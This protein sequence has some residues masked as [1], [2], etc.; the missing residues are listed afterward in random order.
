MSNSADVETLVKE[1]R[2]AEAATKVLA[3]GD[4]KTAADYF[5][6]AW[7]YKRATSIARAQGDLLG[8]LGYA[9]QGALRSETE[10]LR[11][12]LTREP[13]LAKRGAELALSKGKSHD[14]ALLFEAADEYGEASRVYEATGAFVDAARCRERIGEYR[15]AGQ[16][17]ERHLERE[18]DDQEAMLTLAAILVRFGRYEPAARLL[19]PIDKEALRPQALRL[20]VAALSFLGMHE[21][22]A[23][24]YAVLRSVD[25]AIPPSAGEFVAANFARRGAQTQDD[26][27]AT[28]LLG[29]YRV[30][31]TLGSGA[32]GRVVLAKDA[33]YNRDVAIKMLRIGDSGKGRDAFARFSREARIALQLTHPNIVRVIEFDPAGPLLVM[34]WMSGGTLEDRFQ[35]PVPLLRGEIR[36]VLE[37][38][39][40]ALHL[41]HRYGVVHRDIKPSNIFFDATGIPKLGDFGVAHLHDVGATL[42]GAGL[43]TLSY[44]APEQITGA[45][46]PSPATDLYAIGIVAYRML[47]GLLPFRGADVVAQH[48]NEAPPRPSDENPHLGV[49]FD[50]FIE[51]LLAKDPS[52]R[53]A[54]AQE[55]R[56]LLDAIARVDARASVA[57]PFRAAT[58]FVPAE[59]KSAPPSENRYEELGVDGDGARILRDRLLDRRVRVIRVTA[60]QLPEYISRARVADPLQPAVLDIDR[61]AN[62]VTLEEALSETAR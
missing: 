59:S 26:E 28:F 52:K 8:A 54:S 53:P 11:I 62:E 50:D 16:L 2:Y 22:A 45:T 55:A 27:N 39:L 21:A 48:L 43:G 57:L 31:R 23:D 33:L 44:M 18:G 13:A 35:K 34:E 17:L 56:R 29:R 37:G 32:V 42:T 38:L 15:E 6:R 19:Q 5:A 9:L 47:T 12:Q 7:D 51:T 46:Q 1:G 40:D 24:R 14:A 30:L 10:D 25:Q 20:L 3:A 49:D 36:T 41:V 58:A 60:A 61:D 4:A